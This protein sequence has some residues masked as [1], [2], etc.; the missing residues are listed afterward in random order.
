MTWNQLHLYLKPTPS[1][2]FCWASSLSPGRDS[3][4]LAL[5]WPS[6]VS[7]IP[8]WNVECAFAW[9]QYDKGLLRFHCGYLLVKSPF[10]TWPGVLTTLDHVISRE[11]NTSWVLN[12]K[13]KTHGFI[14][15]DKKNKLGSWILLFGLLVQNN[16]EVVQLLHRRS[17][18]RASLIWIIKSLS[19]VCEYGLRKTSTAYQAKTRLGVRGHGSVLPL[20]LI[21]C[22]TFGE[23]L[24][25]SRHVSLHL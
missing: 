13:F 1:S 16:I 25:L 18:P 5:R 15:Y 12:S 10:V 7:T 11:E 20:P 19:R 21:S 23:S 14:L 17:C 22:V 2:W 8:P 3:F 4:L 9:K 24:Y 6:C